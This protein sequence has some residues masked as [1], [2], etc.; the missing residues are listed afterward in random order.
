[1]F[2][3]PPTDDLFRSR[4]DHIIDQ[5]LPLAVLAS[6]MPWQE[7]EAR[8]THVFSRKRR[9][10]VAT[11]DLDFFGKQAQRVAVASNAGQF[12]VPLHI[13]IACCISSTRSTNPTR[14]WWSAEP[15]RRAGWSTSCTGAIPSASASRTKKCSNSAT[16]MS[17]S[18][19]TS[20]PITMW[21]AGTSRTSVATVCTRCCVPRATT[22]DGC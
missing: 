7:I 13:T 14:A 16:R 20:R 17:Q 2:A 1:M 6:P 22:S 5:R 19:A 10:G 12:R 11:P 21:T 8:V 9:V 18:S 3:S 4:Y 15:T